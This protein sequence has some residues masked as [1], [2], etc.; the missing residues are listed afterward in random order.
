MNRA[1]SAHAF[2][3]HGFLGRCPQASIDGAPSALYTHRHLLDS[4]IGRPA[5]FAKATAS[6]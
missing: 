6:F 1:Y 4:G 5:F 2:A 3:V